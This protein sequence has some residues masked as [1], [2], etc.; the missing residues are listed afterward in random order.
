MEK[1]EIRELYSDNGIV[2]QLTDSLKTV[3]QNAIKFKNHI[4][5]SFEDVSITIHFIIE[6]N[7]F[8]KMYN[9]DDFNKYI[10]I[11]KLN[12]IYKKIFSIKKF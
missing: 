5:L 7:E 4:I 12:K 10:E 11:Q 6:W 3:L 9:L 1:I 8:K 2:F